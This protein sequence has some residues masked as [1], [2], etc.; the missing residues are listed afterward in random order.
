MLKIT[1]NYGDGLQSIDWFLPKENKYVYFPNIRLSS[2]SSLRIEATGE[3][4][5]FIAE[6]FNNIPH[7]DCETKQIWNANFARFIIEN[8][9]ILLEE[10]K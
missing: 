8:I 10:Q 1:Y 5:E 2:D 9:P 3:E 4:L 6:N 7:T